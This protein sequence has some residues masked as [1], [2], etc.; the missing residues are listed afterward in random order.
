MY[1]RYDQKNKV[2]ILDIAYRFD[3]PQHFYKISCTVKF[4]AIFN[5]QKIKRTYC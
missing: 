4:L 5:L 1:Y 3:Y 2:C